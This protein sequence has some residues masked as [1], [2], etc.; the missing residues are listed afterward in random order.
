MTINIVIP[1]DNHEERTYALKTLLSLFI[2]QKLLD[3]VI[4]VEETTDY[5]FF[6]DDNEI[7]IN[8]DFWCHW[9]E[10]LS[11]LTPKALPHP[12][13]GKCSFT[14]EQDIVCIYGKPE[15]NVSEKLIICKSDIIAS[16]FFMLTRW[17]EYVN[18]AR[19]IHD[20][21]TAKESIAYK[22]GFLNRPIV[23]EYARLLENMLLHIGLPRRCLS[24]GKFELVLTHDIDKMRYTSVKSLLGDIVKR[25]DL[26]LF[27]RNLQLSFSNPF[28]TYSF[29][30]SESEK[31]G[32][33][34]HFYFMASKDNNGYDY[35]FYINSKAFRN[36]INDI[37]TRGHIIGFHP[38]YTTY[39]NPTKWAIQKNKL[40]A[41]INQVI[42][43][44]RQ[45]Y[46]MMDISTT[47][48]IWADHDMKI[49]STLGY[50]DCIGFRCG[51]GNYFRVFNFL[52]RKE[53]PLLEQ[54]LIVMDGTLRQYMKLSDDEA[55]DKVFEFIDISKKYC[56]PMTI[57]FHNSSF[58]FVWEGCESLYRDILQYAANQDS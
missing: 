26:K 53:M 35:D 24:I 31:Y 21:F 28:N 48:Q 44:G 25:W 43:E 11:Y 34:S 47:L 51:T 33:K 4:K 38:G 58:S 8:D 57:L 39:K 17:E 54:P 50:A 19:D 32:L 49:D 3:V 23:N 37:R 36:L 1:S 41:K 22:Y 29:L 6:V 55:R 42:S 30:M 5:H 18:G 56:M 12:V 16:T 46:L 20:R 13:R 45:H 9:P 10:P 7:I 40:S 2:D 52:T 15:I 27:F 14:S